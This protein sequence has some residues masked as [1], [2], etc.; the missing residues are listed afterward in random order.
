MEAASLGGRGGASSLL[1]LLTAADRGS[2]AAAASAPVRRSRREGRGRSPAAGV[3][4]GRSPWIRPP[5]DAAACGVKRAAGRGGRWGLGEEERVE[6]GGEK[7]EYDAWGPHLVVD[8]E[9]ET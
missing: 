1:R 8:M 6:R 9:F 3:G 4:K 2:R 5:V 7:K